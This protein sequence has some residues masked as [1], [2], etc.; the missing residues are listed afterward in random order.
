MFAH[1]CT[2]HL[3]WLFALSVKFSGNVPYGTGILTIVLK[4]LRYCKLRHIMNFSKECKGID[5][6]SLVRIFSRVHMCHDTI[7]D[8]RS[9]GSI[10]LTQAVCCN[11]WT[12][13]CTK[14]R[15]ATSMKHIE[16]RCFISVNTLKRKVIW[17][18]GNKVNILLATSVCHRDLWL[19]M[20]AVQKSSHL[21]CSKCNAWYHFV[22]ECWEVNFTRSHKVHAQDVR[23]HFI[24]TMKPKPV[25]G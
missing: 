20:E 13:G 8:Q 4:A 21:V 11:L 9:W 5:S 7:L 2:K 17:S 22:V 18:K 10:M 15:L 24:C 14:F 12:K 23:V 19:V 16:C 3:L 6:L 25:S 1:M